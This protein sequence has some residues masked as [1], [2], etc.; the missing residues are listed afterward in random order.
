M[1]FGSLWFT[2]VQ[3]GSVLPG[4]DKAKGIFMMNVYENDAFG[5]IAVEQ[6]YRPIM[7]IGERRERGSGGG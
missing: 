5:V 6:K 7:C 2:V 1:Q 4:L 3:Y